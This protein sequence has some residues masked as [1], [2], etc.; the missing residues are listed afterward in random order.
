MS[1]EFLSDLVTAGV[2]SLTSIATNQEAIEL[3]I[4]D[5]DYELPEGDEEPDGDGYETIYT[6]QGNWLFDKTDTEP[7]AF[8]GGVS[9]RGNYLLC[10]FDTSDEMAEAIKGNSSHDGATHVLVAG[11]R[12]ILNREDSTPPSHIDPVWQIYCDH[13]FV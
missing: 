8:S 6:I 1:A 13:D 7:T 12:Y 2:P 3:Q 10:A 5:E 4:V 9:R 11:K